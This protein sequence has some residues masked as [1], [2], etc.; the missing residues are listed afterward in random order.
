MADNDVMMDG[1]LEESQE[2]NQEQAEYINNSGEQDQSPE[3]Q[4]EQ[5]QEAQDDSQKGTQYTDKGTKLDPNPMSALNQQIANERARVREYEALLSDPKRV[6]EYL[7]ELER[8]MGVTQEPQG[9]QEITIDQVE[10]KE[11]MQLFLAQERAKDQAQIRKLEETLGGF[12][13]NQRSVAIGQKISSSIDEVRRKYPELK[14]TNPDGSPNPRFDPELEKTL[15]DMFDELD[16]DPRTGNYRGTTDL[17]KLAD[18]LMTAAKRGQSQGSRQAQ[19][20]VQDRRAGRV[21]SQGASSKSTPDESKMSAESTIAA[22]IAKAAK[23]KGR[24]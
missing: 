15:G 20:V 9:N 16:L 3:P 14:P 22:R 7:S 4:E 8:E 17:L 1:E 12:L 6:K 21:V 2:D 23:A 24:R 19:T 13:G 10:T 18:R 5:S 11:D